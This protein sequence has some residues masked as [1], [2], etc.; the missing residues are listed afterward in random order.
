VRAA[1]HTVGCSTNS[2]MMTNRGDPY[3]SGSPRLRLGF[4]PADRTLVT[5]GEADHVNVNT[6]S[7][8]VR[9]E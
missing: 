1:R 3:Q 9:P 2:G 4:E 8:I 7:V 6:G 5:S